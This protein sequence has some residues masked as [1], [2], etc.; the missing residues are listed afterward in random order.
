MITLEFL[1]EKRKRYMRLRQSEIARYH[2]VRATLADP[3]KGPTRKITAKMRV[4]TEN[5][6]QTDPVNTV[7]PQKFLWGAT[8]TRP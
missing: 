6:A 8:K 1:Y 7:G 4:G 2:I 5:P 3:A